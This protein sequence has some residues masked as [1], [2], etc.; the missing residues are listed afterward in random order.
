MTEKEFFREVVLDHIVHDGCVLA[1]AETAP[2]KTAFAWKRVLVPALAVLAAILTLTFAI[3]AVRAEVLSWFGVES[4]RDYLEQPADQREPIEALDQMIVSGQ[5]SGNRTEIAPIEQDP[6]AVNSKEAQA[7]AK[8]LQSD[9]HAS[10]EETLYDGDRI[11]LSLHL[12][13]M[14]ALPVLEMFGGGTVT[15]IPVDPMR[16]YDLYEGGPGAEYLSGEKTLYQ[17]PEAFV[18]L[19]F[20]DGT[21]CTGMLSPGDA[22]GQAVEEQIQK[23]GWYASSD[24]L[25]KEEQQALNSFILD[26][27]ANNGVDA[28]ATVWSA[29]DAVERNADADGIAAA[30]IAYSVSVIEDDDLPDTE[31]LYAEL[32]TALINASGYRNM[33]KQDAA[34]S[35]AVAWS[36]EALITQI[37]FVE[38]H[39]N[40]SKV[41][42]LTER[43]SLDG[44]TMR[45]ME[46]AYKDALGVH[47]L[48]VEITLPENASDALKQAFRAEVP[49]NP[50]D[51]TILVNGQEGDFSY[52]SYYGISEAFAGEPEA[53]ENGSLV[54]AI[55]SIAGLPLEQVKE[56]KTVTLIPKLSHAALF[57]GS[58]GSRI[59]I[60][61]GVLSETPTDSNGALCGIQRESVSYPA[62]ALTFTLQ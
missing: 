32:G 23:N 12:D 4:A 37:A 43:V 24:E 60:A 61:E 58:D 57:V 13:G 42:C 21:K 15:M 55:G 18:T 3:P 35:G 62:Y 9:F 10:I 11:Y 59:P 53:A 25:S 30:S 50:L 40:N 27:L 47:D 19:T 39:S 38:P 7:V 2:K 20:A 33:E 17:R 49:F 56:V 44:I 28:I 51:F 46:G 26:Y 16:V 54:F 14:G 41:R 45:A 6:Q 31:L 36:G 34:V 5:P 29:K 1:Y 48:R 8:M 52:G 22:F